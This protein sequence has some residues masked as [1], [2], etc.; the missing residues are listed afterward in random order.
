MVLPTLKPRLLFNSNCSA[1]TG[2]AKSA[3]GLLLGSCVNLALPQ[4][5]QNIS[6]ATQPSVQTRACC[7]PLS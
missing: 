5:V 2:Q 4:L 1:H 3:T 7:E 6:L